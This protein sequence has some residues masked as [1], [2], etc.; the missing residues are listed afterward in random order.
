MIALSR[1]LMLVHLILLPII[2]FV[3]MYVVPDIERNGISLFNI[4][5]MLLY[6]IYTVIAS[7]FTAIYIAIYFYKNM[8]SDQG[9]LTLTLPASP[10]QHLLSKV[11]AGSLWTLIDLLFIDGSLLL[12]YFSSTL[13]EALNSANGEM[14]AQAFEAQ[15]GMTLNQF[16]FFIVVLTLISCIS[17]PLFSYG[18]V[19]AGQLFPSHRVLWAVIIYVIITGISALFGG[20]L[21]ASWSLRQMAAPSDTNLFSIFLVATIASAL[22][23][24]VAGGAIA[25]YVLKKKVNLQ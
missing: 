6:F 17:N 25:Y 13:Q 2:A 12:I 8:F 22:L 20:A 16:M 10:A 3:I 11:L 9:Y 24:A 19:A 4:C 23:F 5:G 14:V 21:G 15:N 7:S 1:V 18:T